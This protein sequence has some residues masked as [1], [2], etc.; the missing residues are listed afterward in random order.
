MPDK[1]PRHVGRVERLNLLLAEP[2]AFSQADIEGRVNALI[3][4]LA[5]DQADY[6]TKN[7]VLAEFRKTLKPLKNAADADKLLV[8]DWLERILDIQGMET[9]DGL[10]DAWVHGVSL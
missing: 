3:G 9:S 6:L 4:L 5:R 7:P 8:C 10:L 1:N 2:K